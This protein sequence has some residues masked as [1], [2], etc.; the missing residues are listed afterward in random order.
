MKKNEVCYFSVVVL[1]TKE[2]LL[3]GV[4]PAVAPSGHR[5]P[6][7]LVFHN[8]DKLI[9]GVM[10]A[11][12]AV[13]DGRA[14]QRNAVILDKLQNRFKDKINLYGVTDHVGKD[15]SGKSVQN[16]GQVAECPIKRDI[17]DVCNMSRRIFFTFITMGGCCT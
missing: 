13:Q 5:L 8:T 11:L 15:L 14:L 12:V 9:T 4:V 1:V 6:Q 17:G 10:A 7:L 16:S 2:A 3:G